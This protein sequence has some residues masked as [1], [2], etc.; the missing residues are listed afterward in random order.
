[1]PINYDGV[2]IKEPNQKVNYTKEQYEELIKC[3]RDIFYYAENYHYVRVPK[4]KSSGGGR[5]QLVS[6]EGRDFQKNLI[7]QFQ[8]N[9]F[10]ICLAARQMGKCEFFD[11][12]ITIRNKKTGEVE[13]ITIGDFFERIETKTE[14]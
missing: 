13:K 8:D 14:K 2:K 10:V 12:E 4:K 3:S 7:N 5:L 9:R 6:F 1:M 11:S